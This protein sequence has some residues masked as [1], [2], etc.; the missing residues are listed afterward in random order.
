MTDTLAAM[1]ARQHAAAPDTAA[2]SERLLHLRA[3]IEQAQDDIHRL[4]RNLEA[5]RRLAV[6]AAVLRARCKETPQG[7]AVLAELTA[8]AQ[9]L[10]LYDDPP[11]LRPEEG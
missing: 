5:Y 3:S 11:P 7:R 8:E 6:R 9:R 4:E 1:E 2:E 10:G